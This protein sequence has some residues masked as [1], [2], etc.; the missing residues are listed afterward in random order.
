[1]QPMTIGRLAHAAGVHVETIRYYQRRGLLAAP[2]RPLGSV[3]RYGAE[4]LARIRFVKRAQ[5]LG[6]TL[7][8]ISGLLQLERFSACGPARAL[9]TRKLASVDA[10]LRDLKRMRSVL[11]RLIAECDSGSARGCAI[12]ESLQAG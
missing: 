12:I 11:T 2:T 5:E 9:A 7:E 6:F 10:R 1:M 4:A 3:R 8:E